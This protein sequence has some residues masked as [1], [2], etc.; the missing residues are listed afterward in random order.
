MQRLVGAGHPPD[1][2]RRYTLAQIEGFLGAIDRRECAAAAQAAIAA[3][4]AAHADGKDFGGFVNR[5]LPAG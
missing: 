1:A 4:F 5:L 2:V 3:R